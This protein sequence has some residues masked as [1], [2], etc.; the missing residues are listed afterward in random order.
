[1]EKGGVVTLEPN[2]YI[3]CKFTFTPREAKLY[4][5]DITIE[6]VSPRIKFDTYHLIALS[7]TDYSFFSDDL[8][9]SPEK[10]IDNTIHF[11]SINSL[12]YNNVNEI[13]EHITELIPIP[14]PTPSFVIKYKYGKLSK[15]KIEDECYELVTLR[16]LEIFNKQ[17]HLII[18]DPF[19]IN[20][21]LDGELKPKEI[22]EIK[23][24]I[25]ELSS[26]TEVYCL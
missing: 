23:I 19:K 16:N 18:T 10:M 22:K 4:M 3:L 8:N 1:M 17:Y 2:S 7:S 20:I 12:I 25:D 24:T 21:D 26:N 6:S 5:C 11:K 9:P 14:I 15:S 13:I